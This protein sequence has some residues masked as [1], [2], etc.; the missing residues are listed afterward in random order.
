[1]PRTFSE[2][3]QE[4][5]AEQMLEAVNELDAGK[6]LALLDSGVP[7]DVWD[8]TDEDGD[9]PLQVVAGM[10]GEA[11]LAIA[12]ALVEAGADIDFQGC[13]E[14]T[15]LARAIEADGSNRDDWA[16]ARYLIGA[17][18]NPSLRD[19]DGQCPA[20][21]ANS[22]GNDDAILAMLDAGM[23]PNL[24]GV[25]GTLIWY[26]SYD[27]PE[28][29]KALLA[30]GANPN[31]ATFGFG[32][33]GETPLQRA[34]E[35]FELGGAEDTFCDIAMQL[36]QAGADP[37]QIDPAPDCLAAFLLARKEKSIFS[38]LPPGKVGTRS[39]PL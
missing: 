30:H 3:E 28:L 5:L 21:Y 37:A 18:A 33:E 10:D 13:Y 27:S 34:K 1:M 11:A 32:F 16:I 9:L 4:A 22:S 25:C 17:R 15:A 6:V 38:G 20:E 36:I 8:I 24:K 14:C 29:V 23:D 31:A 26:V 2:E 39:D 7:A 35:A 19:K 12:K